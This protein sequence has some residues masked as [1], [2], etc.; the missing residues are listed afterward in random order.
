M[1][2]LPDD[3]YQQDNQRR[4]RDAGGFPAQPP[5]REARVPRGTEATLSWAQLD[6]QPAGA[7]SR[8][9]LNAR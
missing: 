4:W 3:R 9:G 2:N 5:Y 1:P 6:R 7:A 8:H